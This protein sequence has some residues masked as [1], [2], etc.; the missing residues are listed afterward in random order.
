MGKPSVGALA[1]DDPLDTLIAVY[2]E[3][4]KQADARRQRLDAVGASLMATAVALGAALVAVAGALEHADR[5]PEAGAYVALLFLV[6][7][8]V[9]AGLSR[10]SV[11]QR[12]NRGEPRTLSLWRQEDESISALG[13]MASTIGTDAP[14]PSTQRVKEETLRLW[15]TKVAIGERS[16]RFKNVLMLWSAFALAFAL[17]ALIFIAVSILADSYP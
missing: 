12:F 4:A 17:A 1:T 5:I 16:M 11:L 15:H 8:V 6:A 10:A 9:L 3:L 2:A 14:Q 7:T 13:T